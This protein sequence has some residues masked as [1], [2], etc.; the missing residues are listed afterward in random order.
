MPRWL[1]FGNAYPCDNFLSNPITGELP[2][3]ERDGFSDN[4]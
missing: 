3:R 1:M 4:A 2:S